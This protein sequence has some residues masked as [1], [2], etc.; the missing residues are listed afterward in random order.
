MKEA[1]IMVLLFLNAGSLVMQLVYFLG[2]DFERDEGY[3]RQKLELF[4]QSSSSWINCGRTKSKKKTWPA[5]WQYAIKPRKRRDMNACAYICA[6]SLS[7]PTSL[8][9]P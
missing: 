3:A 8:L 4:K 6:C 9:K 7:T 2:Q 1:P 5:R